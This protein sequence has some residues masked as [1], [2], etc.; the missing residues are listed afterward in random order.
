MLGLRLPENWRS[1][2]YGMKNTFVRN[3]SSNNR[4][5]IIQHSGAHLLLYSTVRTLPKAFV[6]HGKQSI[7]CTQSRSA[8]TSLPWVVHLLQP[9][10]AA[11]VCRKGVSIRISSWKD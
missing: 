7:I 4:L 2:M 3:C 1:A 10:S 11:T 8:A 9:P 5:S 6:H